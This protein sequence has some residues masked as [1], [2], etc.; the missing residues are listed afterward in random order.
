MSYIMKQCMSDSFLEDIKKKDRLF[1]LLVSYLPN[2]KLRDQL[3]DCRG[4]A[5]EKLVEIII[6]KAKGTQAVDGYG[7]DFSDGSEGKFA[8]IAHQL[9]RQDGRVYDTYRAMIG[10]LATKTGD[11]H[12]VIHDPKAR[13]AD[14]EVMFFT[15]PYEVWR[16]HMQNSGKGTLKLSFPKSRILKGWFADYMQ[17]P[18]EFFSA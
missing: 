11:L 4:I 14:R 17:S 12:V 13:F 7:H 18:K 8:T 10:N 15:F 5:V 2:K 9:Q 1:R 16:S 3:M 6:A